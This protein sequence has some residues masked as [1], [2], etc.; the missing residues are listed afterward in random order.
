MMESLHKRDEHNVT[1]FNDLRFKWD[2]SVREIHDSLQSQVTAAVCW[3]FRSENG[4]TSVYLCLV[5]SYRS[6]KGTVAKIA[7]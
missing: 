6:L 3:V 5:S 1:L 2:L 7:C 4:F